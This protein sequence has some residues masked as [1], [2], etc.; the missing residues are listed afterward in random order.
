[1]ARS[2]LLFGFI[3]FFILSCKDKKDTFAQNEGPEEVIQS[4]RAIPED[5]SGIQFLNK[6][7]ESQNF[8]Y[9]IYPFIYFGGGVSTGDINNDG[10]PDIYFTGQMGKN[11]LYLNKGNM[12]FQDITATA[13]VEGIYNHWTTGTT[14]ADVNN[15]GFLDIYVSVAGPGATRKNLLYINN[16]NNTFSEQAQN[17]GIA[18]VGH[19]IQSAF[20]D[21]DN[22]G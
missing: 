20:F 3:L 4:Y 19:T 8:N 14:M 2:Y 13:G 9:L 21:Y 17:Y 16:K 15:D 11:K 7:Q 5:S 12:S 6:T 22:D 18:D 1:M 10:L